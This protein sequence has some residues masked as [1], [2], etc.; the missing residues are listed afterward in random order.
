MPIFDV[1][2]L[3]YQKITE[4]DPARSFVLGSFSPIEVH[5]PHLPLGEDLFSAEAMGRGTAEKLVK[6]YPDWNFLFLPPCSVAADGVPRL[7]TIVYPAHLVRDVA[8]Y[9]MLPFA[10]AG[11]ARLGFS[12]FHGGPRHFLALEAAAE[13][14]SHVRQGT[15]AISLFSAAIG[16]MVEGQLFY[17]SVKDDPGFSLTQRDLKEDHHAGFVETSLALHLWP[18]L[19]EDGWDDL[20][21]SV[22]KSLADEKDSDSYLFNRSEKRSLRSIAEQGIGTAKAV[23]SSISHF[24]K[25]TYYG[26]PAAATKKRGE[27]LLAA[28]TDLSVDLAVD[29]IEQGDAMPRQSPLWKARHLFL[30]RPV[31][32]TVDALIARQ[33]KQRRGEK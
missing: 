15:A 25:S 31:N 13:K 30:N 1:T 4:L 26:R 16:R 21:P 2:K 24:Q 17:E 22:G 29:F 12:S 19:V 27:K 9:A 28:I 10:E 20:P 33:T 23:A 11:F 3:S 7:G 5:G 18:E 6:K 14:L 32:D 8:Y